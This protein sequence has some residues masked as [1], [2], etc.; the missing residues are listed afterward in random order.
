MVGQVFFRD[1]KLVLP[2]QAADMLAWYLRRNDEGSDSSFLQVEL[3]QIVGTEHFECP[4]PENAL[5]EWGIQFAKF[6]QAAIP[7]S[8]RGWKRLT[9]HLREQKSRGFVPPYGSKWRNRIA[10]WFGYPRIPR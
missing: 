8:E 4:I 6:P 3:P 7:S 10:R 2:I 5:R 9:K 1:D